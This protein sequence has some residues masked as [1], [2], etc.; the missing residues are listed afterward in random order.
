MWPPAAIN[1]RRRACPCFPPAALLEAYADLQHT[2]V[3]VPELLAA[4][5]DQVRRGAAQ[6]LEQEEAAAAAA[7]A[8]QATDA[9]VAAAFAG[10]APPPPAGPAAA[11][12]PALTPAAPAP[13]GS[14]RL[15]GFSLAG[16]NSLLSSH[17]RL[18]Y[19]PPP[20]LLHAL[21]PTIR[22]QLAGSPAEEA[23]LLLQLLA[24]VPLNPGASLVALL[25]GR[26]LDDEAELAAGRAAGGG[27]GGAGSQSPAGQQRMAAAARE[28]AERLLAPGAG[29]GR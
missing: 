13:A 29:G 6:Q 28:A 26:V 11:L 5:G 14:R 2:S 20:L 27:S 23:A 19:A 1:H 4:V 17:L 8:Q 24:A 15:E 22:R 7:A 10:L 18:G 3:V 12:L 16:I 21:A 9:T 25:L